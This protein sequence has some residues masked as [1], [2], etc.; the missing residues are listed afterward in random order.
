MKGKFYC[1]GLNIETKPGFGE[2]YTVNRSV[3][4]RCATLAVFLVALALTS[5][6][7]SGHVHAQDA[8][9]LFRKAEKLYR[10]SDFKKAKALY[11]ESY[12]AKPDPKVLLSIAQC[13]RNLG[14]LNNAIKTYEAFVRKTSDEQA[15]K[16]VKGLLVKLRAERGDVNPGEKTS[17]PPLKPPAPPPALVA[18]TQPPSD[19]ALVIEP[20]TKSSDEPKIYETWTFWTGVLL[21]GASVGVTAALLSSGPGEQEGSLGSIEWK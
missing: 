3:F 11:Q 9:A 17:A 12:R 7:Q 1:F 8:D 13:F 20:P 21:V 15:R 5:S 4:I 10:S 16:G 2:H 6:I 14:E 19:N 18:P